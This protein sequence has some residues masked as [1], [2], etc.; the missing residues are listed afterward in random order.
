MTLLGG[1]Y[2]LEFFTDFKTTW[3]KPFSDAFDVL[4]GGFSIY[5]VFRSCGTTLTDKNHEKTCKITVFV[6]VSS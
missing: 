5:D 3:Q 2:R 1:R 4:K 6:I